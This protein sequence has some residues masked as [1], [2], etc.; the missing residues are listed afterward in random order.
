MTEDQRQELIEKLKGHVDI[1]DLFTPH[2]VIDWTR[3]HLEPTQVFSVP[4]LLT[5][6]R[7]REPH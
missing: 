5:S 1:L 4:E 3:Q 7:M 2:D 6:I